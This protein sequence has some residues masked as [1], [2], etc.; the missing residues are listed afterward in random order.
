MNRES[1]T[2]SHGVNATDSNEFQGTFGKAVVTE[3]VTWMRNVL[4][5]TT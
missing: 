2:P 5:P 1:Y 4:E 3:S